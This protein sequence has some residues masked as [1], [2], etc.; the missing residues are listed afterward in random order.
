VIS[1]MSPKR[2]KPKMKRT[3]L[4][5]ILLLAGG[6]SCAAT[7]AETSS[8]HTSGEGTVNHQKPAVSPQSKE[9]KKSQ[10]KAATSGQSGTKS[11]S[12]TDKS[13]HSAKSTNATPKKKALQSQ[14]SMPQHARQVVD[15]HQANGTKPDFAPLKA[16]PFQPTSSLASDTVKVSA[17]TP[18]RQSV[19]GKSS[20]KSGLSQSLPSVI[21]RSI[22]VP[23]SG[24]GQLMPSSAKNSAASI[25]GTGIRNPKRS[26]NLI[27]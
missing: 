24:L 8:E 4:L 25:N 10:E 2:K 21:Y 7:F 26:A 16:A 20:N 22:A 14:P 27:P 1:S 13:A 19:V 23:H 18:S 5:Q 3:K 15:S 11:S 9:T 6:C 12:V 17:S